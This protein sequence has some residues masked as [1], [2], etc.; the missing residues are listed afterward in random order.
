MQ[1][2]K[3]TVEKGSQVGQREGIC[4]PNAGDSGSIPALG[5]SL[6]EGNG[7]YSCWENPV[8][9]GV[10]RVTAHGVTKEPDTT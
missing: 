1:N 6:G 9:T 7:N 5:R 2:G 8:D 4:L 10:W 3:A